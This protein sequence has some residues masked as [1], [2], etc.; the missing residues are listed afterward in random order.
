MT[1]ALHAWSILALLVGRLRQAWPE[2]K[3]TFR[4]DSGFCRHRLFD[5]C[6]RNNVGYVVGIGG[7]SRLRKLAQPWVEAAQQSFDEAQTKQR[8]FADFGYRAGSWSRQRR[9]VLKAEHT[10]KGSIT[11]DLS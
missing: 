9:I 8:L 2:V 3:I 5:W 1:Q 6:E 7:N 10:A 4:A 11:P